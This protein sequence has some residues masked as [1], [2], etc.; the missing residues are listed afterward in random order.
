M[1]LRLDSVIL[2]PESDVRPETHGINR[3]EQ[4]NYKWEPEKARLF[5]ERLSQPDVRSMLDEICDSMMVNELNSDNINT[6]VTDFT[7]VI[8]SVA[9]PLFKKP[10]PRYNNNA[11]QKRKP[12]WFDTNCED[13]REEFL[14]YRRV[15]EREQT[16][17]SRVKM[18]EARSVFKKNARHCRT[19]Y[20]EAQTRKSMIIRS[21]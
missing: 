16:D 15:Y 1:Y 2:D 6:C 18:T 13:K 12:L 20:C 21:S 7:D 3:T 17:E 5:S 14:H 19:H 9:D 11:G 8:R 10:P 4:C